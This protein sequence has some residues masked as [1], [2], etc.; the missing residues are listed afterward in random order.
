MAFDTPYLHDNLTVELSTRPRWLSLT[1]DFGTIPAGGSTQLTADMDAA[2]MLGGVYPA[3]I[4]IRSNDPATPSLSVPTTLTVIGVPD[5]EVT[6]A[7]LDFGQTFIGYPRSLA[8]TLKN[9]GTDLLHVSGT[10]TAG[11]FSVSGLS[12]PAV[13][14]IGG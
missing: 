2:G 12:T 9:A 11:E 3:E 6:P 13:L 4:R 7:S 14:P 1:P 5:V 10:S 8:V